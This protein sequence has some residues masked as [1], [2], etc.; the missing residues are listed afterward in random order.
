MGMMLIKKGFN[1]EGR[2]GVVVGFKRMD[3]KSERE[4]EREKRQ[5]VAVS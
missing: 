4:R 3:L 1:N 2:R 5:Y